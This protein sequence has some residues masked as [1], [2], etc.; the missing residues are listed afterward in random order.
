MKNARFLGWSI[1][2]YVLAK[3]TLSIEVD[4][5]LKDTLEVHTTA[6]RR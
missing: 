1:Q 3:H 4:F 2:R 6:A 5:M